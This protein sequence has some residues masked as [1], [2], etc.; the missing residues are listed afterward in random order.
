M[1][2]FTHMIHAIKLS[3]QQHAQVYNYTIPQ[4]WNTFG[5]EKGKRLRNHEMMVDPHDFYCFALSK[6]MQSEDHS[7]SIR[8]EKGKN[9][10]WI[11]R[12]I[13]YAMDLRTLTSWDHDRSDA[14]DINNIYDLN[15]SGTFLK[16]IILLPLL[17]RCGITTLILHQLFEL[18]TTRTHHDYAQP[19]AVRH[20]L[21]IASYLRDPLLTDIDLTQQFQ[22]F[23]QAAHHY[24]FRLICNTSFARMGRDNDVLAQHP[25]WFYWI[26]KDEEKHYRAPTVEGL[27]ANCI[28]SKN[29]CKL[30]YQN[31][32]TQAH[33][34]RF[35]YDPCTKNPVE[36]QAWLQAHDKADLAMIEKQFQVT[37]A[38]MFSDQLNSSLDMQSE[39]TYLR[40]YRDQPLH[41]A[42]YLMQ[43]TMRP[44]LFVGKDI[45][46]AVWCFICDC[47]SALIQDYGFDGL[48]L[49]EPWLLPHKLIKTMIQRIRKLQPQCSVLITCTDEQ[50][51]AKW[52]R[53]GVNAISGGSAY[54]VHNKDAFA[55][56]S[57]AYSRI[58]AGSLLFA[59]SEF[60]D[61]PRITQY[62]SKETL[63]KT[64]LF[65]SLFLPN[66]IPYYTSGQFSLEKQ[67]QHLSPFADASYKNAL[68]PS[69]IRCHKQALIDKSYYN[70]TRSDY[71]ILINQMEH[72]TQLRSRYLSAIQDNEACIPV[73]FDK[74]HD[75]GIGFTYTLKDRALLVVCNID[76][77]HEQA[78][79]IHTENMLWAL[80][81]VW[82]HI[83]QVYSSHD[84]YTHAIELNI[85]QN[86]PLHFEAG[87]VKVLEIRSEEK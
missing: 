56:R 55:Y 72:F 43:D 18:D 68:P 87:E 14:I 58:N 6:M 45:F 78:L 23:M 60:L 47:A 25:D 5:Y 86:I 29:A 28:P 8:L 61:T 52:K 76:V 73:W 50:L 19:Y 59:A 40:F 48:L 83:Y 12:E 1:I 71:H 35:S 44:D 36:Y 81:F 33:L 82:K 84:P 26:K 66:T 46:E 34:N 27:P 24:G 9:G 79:T 41:Q 64:L 74:P 80:P 30:L 75:P 49:D 17:K 21:R 67:P 51:F 65:M 32:T 16:A 53:I 2:D 20:P 22:M 13:V 54:S 15:D 63:A 4:S 3:K 69:D 37:S 39:T 70:Y 77:Y 10:S 38:P 62:E 7:R 11:G 57:F 85:F 42:P 31:K